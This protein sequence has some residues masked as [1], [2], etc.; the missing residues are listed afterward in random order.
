MALL[1]RLLKNPATPARLLALAAQE[2]RRQVV[3]QELKAAERHMN[4]RTS[5]LGIPDRPKTE[6]QIK[7]L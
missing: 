2:Y 7:G 5:L 3:L 4:K 6:P 1:L